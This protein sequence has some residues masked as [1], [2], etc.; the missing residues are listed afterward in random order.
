MAGSSALAMP[1]AVAGPMALSVAKAGRRAV[2]GPRAL[3]GPRVLPGPIAIA[4]PGAV[5]RL[6]GMDGSGGDDC[7]SLELL[8]RQQRLWRCWQGG[9]QLCLQRRRRCQRGDGDCADGGTVRARGSAV[10]PTAAAWVIVTAKGVAARQ[11]AAEPTEAALLLV[12]TTAQRR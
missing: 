5:G 11:A 3:A 10:V 8:W 7:E 12:A 6:N 2:T 1:R 4:G 9:R